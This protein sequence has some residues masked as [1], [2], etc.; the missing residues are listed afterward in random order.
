MTIHP[1]LTPPVKDVTAKET[2]GIAQE[3]LEKMKPIV[4][5]RRKL[6]ETEQ[7][8]KGL[9]SDLLVKMD[10]VLKMDS[11]TELKKENLI[12]EKDVLTKLQNIL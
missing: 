3:V 8:I 5:S 4:E 9:L 10:L 2:L 11:L 12:L 6:L 7:E 1:S